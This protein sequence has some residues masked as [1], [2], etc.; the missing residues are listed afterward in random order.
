MRVWSM[1]ALLG[2][3]ACGGGV[4]QDQHDAVV[5]ERD[6]LQSKVDALEKKLKSTSSRDAVQKRRDPRRAPPDDAKVDAWLKEA[7]ITKESKLRAVIK[8][9]MGDIPCELFTADAPLTVA[10]FVALAEGKKEWTHPKTNEKSTKP[11]YD[12]TIFHRVIKGFMIQG[13]DPLGVGRGGP[14][15]RFEDEVGNGHGFDKPGV[16]AM[17]N[18]GPR[19]NGSQFFVTEKATPWL[20][21]KHTIFGQ[22]ETDVSMKIANVATSKPG[23]RPNEDV[24][25]NTIEIQRL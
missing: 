9:N 17:A 16:L 8:T 4:P 1:V 15:Y 24:V 20:N 2:L 3:V 12:G 22:C 11:L 6:A 18:S 25:I 10:N 19:T 21:D 23:D 14:G 5:K 7:G 13:G